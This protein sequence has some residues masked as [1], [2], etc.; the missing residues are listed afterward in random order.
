MSGI[1]GV[2]LMGPRAE[3]QIAQTLREA[4]FEI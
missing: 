2:H 3:E 4:A 1:A